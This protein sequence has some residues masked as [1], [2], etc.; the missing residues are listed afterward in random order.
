MKAHKW[1]VLGL[2]V[3]M[4]TLSGSP[5]LWS[6]TV[7]V[8]GLPVLEVTMEGSFRR[9]MS[10]VNGQMR[11]TDTDGTV[12][13]MPAKFKTRGATASQYMMKPSFN[14]KLRNEDYTEEADSALLG[15]RS[16]SSWI[17]DGM[18]IDR[19]C[20]RN[21]V[22][23]DIWNDFSRLPYDTKFDGR[24]GT[25]GRFVEVYINGH[26][27]GIYCL[28]DRIN[29]KLLDLKKVQEQPDGRMLI[30]GAL[31]KSGT[32]DIGN[33]N[34][35]GYSEDSAACVVS[36]HNAWELSYP[37]DYAGVV[38]WAPLQEAFANGNTAAYIKQYFYLENLADYQIHVMA[39]AI[40]D[41]WGNKNHFLSVR[42]I[43][44]SISDADPAQ[45]AKR[46]FVLTPWDLDTSLGGHYSGDYYDG[47][48][49]EWP[50]NS[51][52]KN[53][54]YPISPVVSDAQYQAILKQRWKVAR[55]GAFSIDSVNAKLERY[56]DL[57]L[58]TGAW[59]RMTDHFESKGSNKP[60][61]VL[62]LAREIEYIEAWYAAR[63][64]EMDEYFGL[65]DG[66]ENTPEERS[67]GVWYDLLGRN[68]GTATPAPGV[69]I[70]GGRVVVVKG[71]N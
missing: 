48:Y 2:V 9:G 61:Y 11:L 14:M 52:S 60:K 37:E 59:Q 31:Y 53:A 34:D 68:L 6:Q 15:M 70:R 57:F 54:L 19:I 44:K 26:Y 51:I 29:R 17:L 25:E 66:L 58:T 39:L 45:A 69:Y 47:T 35:P 20:M 8:N 67:D 50:A 1:I 42:D 21:R 62:D 71:E 22:A 63:Y 49:T 33:Q 41:N 40:A 28:N 12:V 38:T 56:R 32:N 10:Y 27:Y 5:C 7:E 55:A 64:H 3:M 13:A 65:P 30:R 18:A 36:W 46:K 24:N 43:S 16:C 4:G 23:F